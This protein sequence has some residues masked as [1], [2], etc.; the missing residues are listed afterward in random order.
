MRYLLRKRISRRVPSRFLRRSKESRIPSNV[1][2]PVSESQNTSV[3]HSN[4]L[5]RVF[6]NPES[7]VR[8]NVELFFTIIT[9]FIGLYFA[10]TANNLAI[11]YGE[12]QD[13][14]SELKKITKKLNEQNES[15]RVIAQQS[16]Q[17]SSDIK[18]QLFLNRQQSKDL[19]DQLA[20]NTK[21]HSNDSLQ[22][23]A[24][25]IHPNVRK[26]RRLLFDL[27]VN[28]GPNYRI[29]TNNVSLEVVQELKKFASD[30]DSLLDNPIYLMHPK[31]RDKCL[32]YLPYA[33][34]LVESIERRGEKRGNDYYFSDP[35]II[36]DLNK[37]FENLK[38]RK[39]SFLMIAARYFNQWYK[40]HPK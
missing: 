18:E 4:L 2:L 16:L 13:Q 39:S 20:L 9:V 1:G 7:G 11:K 40:M 15:L 24:S 38:R 6:L 32:K 8:K 28:D 12:Q 26:A 37:D 35:K 21:T 27:T 25:F 3:N 23:I 22:F 30:V 19:G 10:W 14:I 17:Q 33:Q 29:E 5:R 31:E 34:V 36:E